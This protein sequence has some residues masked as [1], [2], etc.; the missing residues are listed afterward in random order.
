[1]ET[2]MLRWRAGVAR[3]DRIRNDVIRQ[4][5]I[6]ASIAHNM[7]E[8]RLICFML[9]RLGHAYEVYP[10]IGL[11]TALITILVSTAYYSF[12]KIEVWLDRRQGMKAPWD[13]ER[14]RDDYWKKGTVAFDLDGRT[15]K[16]C[17]MMEVLQDEMLAAAK[18]RG[19]R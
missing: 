16:R 11:A 1:M 3:V 19:T 5:F 12:T 17:E 2:K 6:V 14:S 9:R 8:A 4:K 13:W 18:K 7:R 10:L 15:R